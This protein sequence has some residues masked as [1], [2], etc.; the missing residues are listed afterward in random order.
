MPK[1]LA[2]NKHGGVTR[3][4]I[5]ATLALAASPVLASPPPER[6][7]VSAADPRAAAAGAEILRM[8][9][10][11]TDAAIATMLAIDAAIASIRTVT[12]AGWSASIW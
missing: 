8:G 6:G 11:A 1:P 2:A 12:F 7:V 10:S 5:A 4:L 3:L 9:G